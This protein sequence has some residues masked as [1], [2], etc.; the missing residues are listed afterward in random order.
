MSKLDALIR[1]AKARSE[2]KLPTPL[3]RATRRAAGEKFR[4]Q[5]VEW[6]KA[7]APL[8]LK[9]AGVPKDRIDGLVKTL[10]EFVFMAAPWRGKGWSYFGS[11]ADA[12]GF[13][14]GTY[15]IDSVTGGMGG[16]TYPEMIKLWTD[17]YGTA[18]VGD[19]RRKVERLLA[20]MTPEQKALAQFADRELIFSYRVKRLADQLDEGLQDTSREWY[21]RKLPFLEWASKIKPS[22]GS[23]S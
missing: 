14:A 17:S 23:E 20:K 4:R 18:A 10:R 11:Q 19:V 12:V 16:H 7:D 5:M 8:R 22:P 2:A 13:L 1:N 6:V 15:T 9:P 3:P 21:E